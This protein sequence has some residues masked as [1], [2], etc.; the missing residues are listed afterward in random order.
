M[1][2]EPSLTTLRRIGIIG[3]PRYAD[4]TSVMRRLHD[5]AIEHGYELHYG[6]DVLP[7]APKDGVSPVPLDLD[8]QGVDLLITLGGDGTL[9]RGARMVAGRE[10]AILGINLG[11]LGFLTGAQE[12]EVESALEH[13]RAGSYLLDRRYTLEAQVIHADGVEGECFVALNDIVLHKAGVARVVRLDLSVGD[14]DGLDEIGSFSADGVIVATPTGSTAYSLSAGGPIIA[15]SVDCLVVTPIC[16]HTLAVRPLVLPSTERVRIRALD[17]K[18]EMVL[19]V[20][21]QV[22][23]DLA[24]GDLVA[25]RKGGVR[26]ALVRFPGQTFFSTLRRKLNWA[27]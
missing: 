6:D 18:E 25:V 26:I 5:F 15:P 27:V 3:Q 1:P 8:R 17:R 11:Y 2:A 21:G 16:P 7:L 20:D 4:L 23:R 13:I 22:G 24:G 19:T 9:L 12:D 14:G 10:T